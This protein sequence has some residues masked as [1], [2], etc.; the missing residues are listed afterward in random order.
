MFIKVL[1][2]NIAKDDLTSEWG[3]AIYIEYRGHKILLDTGASEKFIQNTQDMGMDLSQI[4]YGVLSH[5]HY[6]H[7]DGMGAFFAVNDHAKFYL[8]DAAEENCYDKTETSEKYIGIHKGF[9]Q[10]YQDRIQYVSGDYELFP[11]VSLIPH[12]TPG[13]EEIGRKAHMYIKK[14]D[15]WYPDNFSHEQSLVFDTEQGLVIFNSCSHGGADN[16]IREIETTYPNKKIYALIGGLHLF[17]AGEEDVRTLA[18]RV[19]KLG[20]QKIYTG[21]CTGNKACRILQEELGTVVEQFYTGLEIQI[22]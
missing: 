5:A 3:L 2:D 19:R 7:S 22:P 4:E 21:H 6:D 1:I 15:E 8:R 14:N 11:G 13:L 20:I 12:K 18:D 9:L 17:E 10:T 16:I